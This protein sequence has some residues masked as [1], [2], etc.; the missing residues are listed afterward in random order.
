[1]REARRSGAW[2][3]LYRN[4]QSEC[5]APGPSPRRGPQVERQVCVSS[6]VAAVPHAS[7]RV[8]VQQGSEGDPGIAR[9]KHWTVA[10]PRGSVSRWR[11]FCVCIFVFNYCRK[12][13]KGAAP[14]DAWKV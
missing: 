14:K 11:D 10:V 4:K 5:V 2:S 12:K 6:Q 1:M 3:L 9:L 13:S 8:G 7:C